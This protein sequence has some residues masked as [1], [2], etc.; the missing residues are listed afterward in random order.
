M[1]LQLKKITI[2]GIDIARINLLETLQITNSHINKKK[3]LIIFTANINHLVKTKKSREFRDIYQ[4]ADLVVA[5]GVP[6]IWYS[7]IF[8]K[9]IPG[10]VNGTDLMEAILKLCNEKKLNI[11]FLGSTL[12]ILIKLKQ[13]TNCSYPKLEIAGM[14]SPPHK[15]NFSEFDLERLMKK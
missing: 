4:Q 11:F 1:R 13:I 12:K 7:K 6:L 5:D 10:R 9:P 8:G 14:Y 15:N 2:L 3:Q